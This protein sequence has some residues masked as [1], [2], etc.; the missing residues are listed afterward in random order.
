MKTK[1]LR[2]GN[3][4]TTDYMTGSA[5]EVTAIHT[6]RIYFQSIAENFQ[7]DTIPIYIKPIPLTEEW[8]LKFGFFKKARCYFLYKDL[9]ITVCDG[10]FYFFTFHFNVELKYVHQLQN[11]YFALT[12][13][14]LTIKET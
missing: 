6:G 3:L 9:K 10:K 8:L 12:G 14:E 1:E 4:V 11:L 2:L 7:S 5:F 13:E